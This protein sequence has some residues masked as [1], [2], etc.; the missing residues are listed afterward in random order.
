MLVYQRVYPVSPA[1]TAVW[2]GKR[3]ETMGTN[4]DPASRLQHSWELHPESG[5]VQ[6]WI[7]I[8]TKDFCQL[9]IYIYIQYFTIVSFR[10]SFWA[11]LIFLRTDKVPDLLNLNSLMGTPNGCRRR[12][13]HATWA[14]SRCELEVLPHGVLHMLPLNSRK[15]GYWHGILTLY[16]LYVYVYI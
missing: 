3:W 4:F 9:T 1:K 2:L 7:K 16:R 5:Q 15:S 12:H 13:S 8:Q 14:T 11:N 10:V 6:K